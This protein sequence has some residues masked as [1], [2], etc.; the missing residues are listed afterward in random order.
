MENIDIW[1]K[2]V[3]LYNE[4]YTKEEY[5]LQKLWEKI[6]EQYF[7]YNSLENEIDTQ[8]KIYLGSTERVIPDIILKKEGKDFVIVELKKSNINF[9]E[10][11]EGQLFSYLKQLK[12]SIGILITNK[13][14]LYLYDYT[15]EDYE[16]QCVEINFTKDNGLG[17]K[18]VELFNKNNLDSKTI[19]DFVESNYKIK[20]DLLKIKSITT[21]SFMK[22]ILTDYYKKSGFSDFAIDE[23][24]K[25]VNISIKSLK[26]ENN[27]SVSVNMLFESMIHSLKTRW[28]SS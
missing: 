9:N 19:R 12:T 21:E 13:I 25:S 20:D 6:F 8:R 3:S 28:S 14:N 7:H 23:F 1:N 2:I 15:K 5:V 24:V 22:E 11:H 27:H 16:Q 17:E 10:K 26:E 4:N 18:F